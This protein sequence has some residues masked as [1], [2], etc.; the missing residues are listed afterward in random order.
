MAVNSTNSTAGPEG[1]FLVILF[2]GS[3]PLPTRTTLS[4]IHLTCQKAIEDAKVAVEMK[5]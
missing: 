1:L 4:V 2:F 3:L 5:K